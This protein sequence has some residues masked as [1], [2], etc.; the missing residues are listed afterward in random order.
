MVRT[1]R[2]E[3]RNFILVPD[4]GDRHQQ[5]NWWRR[6]DADALDAYLRAGVDVNLVNKSKWTPLHSAARYN[7]DASI[8]RALLQV[9]AVVDAR[10]R[11][12]D[13]PLH[14]AAAENENVDVLTALIDAGAPVNARDRFG[15]QPLHTA[16]ESNANPEI[17]G[18]LL[19]AGA[20][21]NK[22]AYFLLFKPGFLLKHNGRMS[23][24]DKKDALAHLQREP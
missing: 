4:T 16:A 6:L 3:A 5:E 14:W 1:R 8:V 23:D 11:S 17:I 12:G 2:R 21:R 22:R 19:D 13:T 10:N 18:A 15:W 7:P 24:A 20:A 9:G